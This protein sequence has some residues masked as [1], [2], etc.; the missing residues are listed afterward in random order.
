MPQPHGLI[1]WVAR[2][3]TLAELDVSGWERALAFGRR[4]GLSG[5]WYPALEAA[6][7]LDALPEGVR[8]HLWSDHLVAADR[9]RGVR[10]EINRISH[11]LAEPGLE[12]VLLKGAAYIASGLAPGNCRMV[13]DVDILVPYP[14]LPAV[15]RAL[16]AHGW[17]QTPHDEYDE[18][19]YREWMH[20]LP[21]FQHGI[22]GTSLDV[23]HN[24]LPR[25]SALC[26][27]AEALLRRAHPLEETG[28][29]V[30]EPA[31]MV[32]HSV[33]HGFYGGEFLNCFRDVLDVHELCA[34]FAA[35]DA[36]F[37]ARL[38]E[39]ALELRAAA[40]LW[41]ALRETRRFPG[42]GAPATLLARLRRAAGLWPTGPLVDRLI[43]HSFL[44]ALPP[45]AGQRFAL[46]A[47]LARSHW[48]KMPLSILLP[49]LW[50]KTAA[51]LRQ[52]FDATDA[53]PG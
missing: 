18:R 50:R 3:A 29:R 9:V 45:S 40:P 32:M 27:D 10:W 47:L 12:P 22:R 21:P 34:E 4:H 44:P 42:D 36:D 30:L 23:H 46:T 14:A 6:G 19:Y 33:L 53:E 20:E 13:S 7:L 52:R 35:R 11:A 2:P 39:R 38:G 24:I 26:P 17:R 5:R 1:D 28:C 25:T 37:W 43:S 51:R 8:R 48:V 49:H 41:L 15:E 16:N 31:D